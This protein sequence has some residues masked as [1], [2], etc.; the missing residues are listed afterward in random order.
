MQI[1]VS[2]VTNYTSLTYYYTF[3]PPTSWGRGFQ[4]WEGK[5]EN[6]DTQKFDRCQV[7]NDAHAS[8]KTWDTIKFDRCQV[9]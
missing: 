4:P 1:R 8:Q 7:V 9:V 6:L 2:T 5:T 3:V